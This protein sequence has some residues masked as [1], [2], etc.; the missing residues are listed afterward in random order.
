MTEHD[1]Y[2]RT[3]LGILAACVLAVVAVMLVVSLLEADHKE[4]EPVPVET[5]DTETQAESAPPVAY[6]EPVV[7]EGNAQ[8]ATVEEPAYQAADRGRDEAQIAFHFIDNVDT[9][10]AYEGASGE[11]LVDSGRRLDMLKRGIPAIVHPH[12]QAYAD[13]AFIR[14]YK[15]CFETF[16]AYYAPGT[17]VLAQ[18]M[19]I[20]R[21]CY[22]A[23]IDW[24]MAA[25]TLYAE[26]NWGR[27]TTGLVWGNAY[28]VHGWISWCLREMA[29]PNDVDCF[30]NEFHMPANI[31]TYR[32]NFGNVVER[33][34]AWRP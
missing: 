3:V 21:A 4:P 23:G 25:A 14:Y 32:F 27:Q 22:E 24:E 28:D 7:Q 19:E 2:W 9:Y 11:H 18:S 17:P 33:A 34:R 5:V 1:K 10:L 26:S 8:E 15:L 29:D 6:V 13:A 20:A 16:M 31:E 30:V 12:T